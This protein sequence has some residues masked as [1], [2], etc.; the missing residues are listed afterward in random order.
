MTNETMLL[1]SLSNSLLHYTL[2]MSI[3]SETT[4][5]VNTYLYDTARS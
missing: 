4:Q 1:I 2:I 3:I 5:N